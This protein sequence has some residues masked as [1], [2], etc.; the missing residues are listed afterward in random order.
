VTEAGQDA[1]VPTGRKARIVATNPGDEPRNEE[2]RERRRAREAAL[3][4]LYQCEIGGVAPGDAIAMHGEIEQA[5]RL[6]SPRAEA[7]ASRLVLGTVEHAAEIEPLIA[8]SAD[9][10]RPERMAVI[11]RLI[12]RMAVF[13]LVHA[14]DVPPN[15]VINEAV[16]LA[17]RFGGDESGR[18][19][20]GV[21]DA[22]KRRRDNIDRDAKKE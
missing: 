12:L 22:I 9:H 1:H 13:Q 11:D 10:W 3:Q 16:E 8:A 4:M 7:F 15:V 17:R 2:Y 14:P 19:V 20:N 5:T 18:F 6:G 21:L